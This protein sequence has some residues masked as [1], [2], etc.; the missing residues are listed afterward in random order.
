MDKALATVLARGAGLRV[1]RSSSR[2]T[3]A[4]YSKPEPLTPWLPDDVARELLV[5]KRAMAHDEGRD[6]DV[7]YEALEPEDFLAVNQVV[8]SSVKPLRGCQLSGAAGLSCGD[9]YIH[10]PGLSV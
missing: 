5:E 7:T 1:P 4:L 3:S 8:E 2:I 6:V 9:C 10:S